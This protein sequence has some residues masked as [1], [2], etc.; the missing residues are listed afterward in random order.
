M[1]GLGKREAG[2]GKREA[3]GRM[4]G[5]MDGTNRGGAEVAEVDAERKGGKC[6]VISDQ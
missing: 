3:D 5:W 1:A 4:D 2:S 6:R